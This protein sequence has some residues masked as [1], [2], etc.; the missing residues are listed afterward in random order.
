MVVSPYARTELNPEDLEEDVGGEGEDGEEN[1]D[2]MVTT[3]PEDEVVAVDDES[4]ENED[5]KN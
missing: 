4:P 5:P 3:P 1:V 2:D